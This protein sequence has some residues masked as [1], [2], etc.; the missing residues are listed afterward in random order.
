MSQSPPSPGG[1]DVLVAVHGLYRER[2]F[3]NLFMVAFCF[4]IPLIAG[5]VVEGQ[6]NSGL[7]PALSLTQAVE[8]AKQELQQ[9]RYPYANQPLLIKADETNSAWN[10]RINKFPT[11]LNLPAVKEMN[12]DRQ[13]YWAIY[14]APA[15]STNRVI[16]GGDAYVFIGRTN[17]QVLGVLLGR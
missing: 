13:P 4:L 6:K 1:R 16:K 2:H 10:L 9:R 8:I 15:A 14:V 5:C 17:G 11:V 12:L 7:P 3:M